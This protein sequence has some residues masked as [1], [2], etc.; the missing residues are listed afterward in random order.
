MLLAKE[1]TSE[2]WRAKTSTLFELKNAEA[3][4]AVAAKLPFFTT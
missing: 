1:R 4:L 2:C 3:E